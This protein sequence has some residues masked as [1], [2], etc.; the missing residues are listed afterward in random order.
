MIVS[1]SRRTD[2]PAFYA[3]WFFNR[4]REGFV[5]VRNPMNA[6]QVRRVELSPHSVDCFVFW[7]K[8]PAPMIDRLALL[9]DYTYYFQF[10]VNGYGADIEPCVPPVDEVTATFARLSDLIGPRRVVWRYDPVLFAGPIDADY[11]RRRFEAI[12]GR[13]CGRTERCMISFVDIY[14]KMKRRFDA[15]HGR[16][17]SACQMRSLAADFAHIASAYGMR[18]YTCAEKIDLESVGVEHGCCI[19]G[20]LIGAL[21]EGVSIA[22]RASGQRSECGCVQSVDIGRY[23][24]CMHN[25]LYCYANVGHESVMRNYMAHDPLSPFM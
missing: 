8:N 18:V 11:H 23:N 17:L 14:G 3:D 2:I 4:L 15:V 21:S 13:L 16:G 25:C 12:A 24:T 9:D 6:S 22:K 10:T 19:D 1:V 20:R 5:C 7:S